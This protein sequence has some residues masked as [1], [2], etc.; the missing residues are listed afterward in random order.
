MLCIRIY[1]RIM[2]CTRVVDGDTLLSEHIMLILL[3]DVDD[4]TY[5][6]A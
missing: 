3:L 2:T 4:N 6:G 1:V 5:I